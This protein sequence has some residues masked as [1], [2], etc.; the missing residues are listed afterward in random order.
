MPQKTP[1]IGGEQNVLYVKG[2]CIDPNVLPDGIRDG[3]IAKAIMD[4]DSTEY[5]FHYVP[6]IAD[7]GYDQKAILG[8][9]IRGYLITT[10]VYGSSA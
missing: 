10:S 8:Q 4:G 9:K 7:A 6:A 2:N 5:E 3:A 1:F